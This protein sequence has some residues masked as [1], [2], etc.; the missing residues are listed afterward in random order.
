VAVALASCHQGAE[1]PEDGAVLLRVN[2]APSGQRP[3]ELRVWVYCDDGVLFD[4]TRF[5][6]QGTLPAT[7]GTLLGSIL[8]SPGNVAGNLR[9]Y[10]R[11]LYS[12]IAVETGTLVL[13]PAQRNGTTVDIFLDSPSVHDTDT[14]GDGVPDEID[15]CPTVSDPQQLGCPVVNGAPDGGAAV[16]GAQLQPPVPDAGGLDAST[17]EADAAIAGDGP[18]AA[19][20]PADAASGAPDASDAMA[21]GLG[22]I[23]TTGGECGSGFCADGVCCNSACDQPCRACFFGYCL[24]VVRVPDFP[25]CAGTMTCNELAMCVAVP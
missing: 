10:V 13:P 15:D 5:P 1:P 11:G 24:A 20:G 6:A 21:K 8:V 2:V 14:D 12:G 23:C 25:Q 3:S 18:D 19:S 16:D 22:S 4:G 17:P 9:I 7:V